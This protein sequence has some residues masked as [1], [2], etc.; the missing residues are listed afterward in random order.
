MVGSNSSWKLAHLCISMIRGDGEHFIKRVW[1]HVNVHQRSIYLYVDISLAASQAFFLRTTRLWCAKR[2]S[3][4]SSEQYELVK[5]HAASGPP[6]PSAT[7]FVAVDAPT[8]PIMATTDGLPLLQVDPQY[9]SILYNF[10]V[11]LTVIGSRLLNK[12]RIWRCCELNSST[13]ASHIGYYNY[14]LQCKHLST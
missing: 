7:I 3:L 9:F 8:G 12:H 13:W 6:G 11:I 1:L 14:R 10:R 2:V 4:W 5:C